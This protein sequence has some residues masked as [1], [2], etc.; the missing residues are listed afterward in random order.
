MYIPA[1]KSFYLVLTWEVNSIE[2]SVSN[3]VSNIEI[4]ALLQ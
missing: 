2:N 4:Y 3:S 1:D